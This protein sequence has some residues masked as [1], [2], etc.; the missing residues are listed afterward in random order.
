MELL[1]SGVESSLKDAWEK[2]DSTVCQIAFWL[3]FSAALPSV[4]E[5]TDAAQWQLMEV[6]IEPS[7]VWATFSN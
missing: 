1:S 2:S 3:S 7:Q 4:L 6:F 5:V